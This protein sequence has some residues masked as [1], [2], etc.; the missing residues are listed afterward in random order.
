MSQPKKTRQQIISIIDQ[1]KFM[2]RKLRV[3]EKGDGFLVQMRYMEP[4]VEHP[5]TGPQVQATRKYYISPYMTESE[6]VETIWLMVQRSQIHVA[7]EHFTY[8]GRRVYSQHFSVSAR[9]D[10]CDG[11]RYDVRINA[12]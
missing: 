6:I 10:L 2:D 4:D 5:E 7:S 3:M 9:I 1:I 11:L 12:K 8:K